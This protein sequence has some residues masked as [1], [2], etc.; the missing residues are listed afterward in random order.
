MRCGFGWVCAFMAVIIDDIG[1]Y[2]GSFIIW[3]VKPGKVTK[4]SGFDRR[5]Q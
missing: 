4:E 3:I 5:K 2:R 1:R